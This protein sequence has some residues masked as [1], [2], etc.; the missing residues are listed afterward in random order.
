[1]SFVP[2]TETPALSAKDFLIPCIVQNDR[3][4]PRRPLAL[5]ATCSNLGLEGIS[6][7]HSMNSLFTISH[8]NPQV[9][10]VSH[11]E[12]NPISETDI[13]DIV[14]NNSIEL[15]NVMKNTSLSD[16]I[17]AYAAEASVFLQELNNQDLHNLKKFLV[18]LLNEDEETIQIGAIRGLT[19]FE[20]DI[21]VED[22]I[23]LKQY[24]SSSRFV[25]TT[26]REALLLMR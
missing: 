22:L 21:E 7:L 24:E 10:I 13:D 23:E 25:K 8:E 3:P 15:F 17:R 5:V 9:P 11:L 20:G 19:R 2:P 16:P 18:G 6:S 12:L 26:V 4:R 1:M 14:R